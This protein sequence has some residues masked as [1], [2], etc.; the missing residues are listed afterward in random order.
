MHKRLTTANNH[1]PAFDDMDGTLDK[2]LCHLECLPLEIRHEIYRYLLKDFKQIHNVNPRTG[3]ITRP[4]RRQSSLPRLLSVSKAMR[5]EVADSMLCGRI[6]EIEIDENAIVTNFSTLDLNDLNQSVTAR[7]WDLG[8]LIVNR[9]YC[10]RI[11]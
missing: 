7:H 1:P 5:R 6:A 9:P 10:P 8:E 11:C 2:P 4:A 3:I